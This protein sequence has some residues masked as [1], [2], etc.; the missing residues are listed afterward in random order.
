MIPKSSNY[1][2]YLGIPHSGKFVLGSFPL[3][4]TL[5]EKIYNFF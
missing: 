1:I 2:F 3:L 4:V 5:V